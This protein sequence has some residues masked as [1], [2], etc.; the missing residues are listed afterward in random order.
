MNRFNNFFD[1]PAKDGRDN[2]TVIVHIDSGEAAEKVVRIDGAVIVPLEVHLGDRRREAFGAQPVHYTDSSVI[3]RPPN[4]VPLKFFV[5]GLSIVADDIREE[6][7]DPAADVRTTGASLDLENF[8]PELGIILTLEGIDDVFEAWDEMLG[9]PV[10]IPGVE[11]LD[12][13]ENVFPIFD[14][15]LNID[16]RDAAAGMKH[17]GEVVLHGVHENDFGDSAFNRSGRRK[18]RNEQFVIIVADM[19]LNFFTESSEDGFPGIIGVSFDERIVLDIELEFA[20]VGDEFTSKG[21]GVFGDMV[22]DTLGDEDP[23]MVGVE[24][25]WI[26]IGVSGLNGFDEDVVAFERQGVF[27][28]GIAGFKGR[29][30]QLLKVFSIIGIGEGRIGD[31]DL[32]GGD[33][34]GS[35]P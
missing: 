21:F 32:G 7:S 28:E 26:M 11:F 24:D 13:I 14:G 19:L 10:E 17:I 12:A 31:G 18:I 5:V 34:H 27:L 30:D 16:V 15:S 22:G 1:S 4:F 2:L 3:L 35:G 20:F 8:C 9:P 33:L 23:D 6:V 29:T 25:K